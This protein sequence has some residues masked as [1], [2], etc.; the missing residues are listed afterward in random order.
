MLILEVLF[1]ASVALVLYTCVAYPLTIALI[2]RLSPVRRVQEARFDGSLS[3]I[4]AAH[5][6]EERIERRL[7]E[8]TQLLDRSGRSGE[9]IVVS[10]GS[11][12]NTVLLAQ[13]FADRGVK[14]IS[15]PTNVGKAAALSA[16]CAAAEYDILVF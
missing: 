10:D 14:V 16:A 9:V 3:I 5:N 6:E 11:T 15:L 1:W 2:A 7:D 8:L 4:L 12:D 13:K